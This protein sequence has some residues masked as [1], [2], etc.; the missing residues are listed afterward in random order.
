MKKK[1]A[2]IEK[3]LARKEVWQDYKKARVL[4]E[5]L[6]FLKKKEE[7]FLEI[8][9]ILEEILFF[10]EK[11]DE[12]ELLGEIAGLERKLESLEKYFFFQG[13]YDKNNAYLM[14]QAGAGGTDACDWV[15]ILL[16]MYLKFFEKKKWQAKIIDQSPHLEAGFRSVTLEITGRYVYGF[17]KGEKGVH[18]LVRIS[19]FDAEKMRHTSFALVEVLPQIEEAKVEINEKDLKI[20]TFL[21]SGHGGQNVQKRET[22]VRIIHLPTG[23]SASS[24]SERSQLQNKKQALRILEA[25]LF[26]LSSEEKEKEKLKLKGEKKS[27]SW[28]NQVRSYVF[29]PYQLVKDLRTQHETS[30]LE[31]VLEGELEPF[32]DAYLK[33]K[34]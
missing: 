15:K 19:P 17:L 4:N 23:L 12:T 20:E 31:S 18:R 1:R 11:I 27:I 16:R 9:K 6:V 3:E 8:E 25:R 21:A 34:R 14:L 24:Q 33:L 28:G 10:K 7:N 30:D 13:E 29:H 26:L 32:I 2:Q 22:A 5:E